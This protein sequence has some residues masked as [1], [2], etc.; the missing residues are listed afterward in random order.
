MLMYSNVQ[1]VWTMMD[2]VGLCWIMSDYV[3]VAQIVCY[4]GVECICVYILRLN[5]RN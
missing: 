2:Y 1:L 4:I 3:V 5:C